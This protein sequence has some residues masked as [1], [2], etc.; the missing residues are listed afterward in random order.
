MVT[1]QGNFSALAQF[2]KIAKFYA[3][4]FI[5]PPKERGS[6]SCQIQK[7]LCFRLNPIRDHILQETDIDNVEIVQYESSSKY[8]IY[9]EVFSKGIYL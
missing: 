8:G 4:T 3:E 9:N 1:T 6:K 7:P 2:S 5:S